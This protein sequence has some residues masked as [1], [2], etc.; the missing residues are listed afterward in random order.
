MKVRS[1]R[2][3]HSQ[4]SRVTGIISSSRD[5]FEKYLGDRSGEDW[6]TNRPWKHKDKVSRVVARFC[7][8]FF[9]TQ[10]RVIRDVARYIALD[11]LFTNRS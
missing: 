9:T 1:G 2:W 11:I 10:G 5:S 8:I 6:P 7:E 3:L 4:V